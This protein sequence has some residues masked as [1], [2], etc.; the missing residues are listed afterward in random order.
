M[1]GGVGDGE[2][3]RGMED[4]TTGSG[5]LWPQVFQQDRAYNFCVAYIHLAAIGLNIHRGRVIVPAGS[6]WF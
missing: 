4:H 1:C 5:L 3:L 6:F 2:C